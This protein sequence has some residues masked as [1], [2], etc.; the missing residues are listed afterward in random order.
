MGV[1][2]YQ[3]GVVVSQVPVKTLLWCENSPFG[4][5]DELYQ[6]GSN[7]VVHYHST[8]YPYFNNALHQHTLIVCNPSVVISTVIT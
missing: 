6:S 4:P 2:W 3:C 5:M 1:S 7:C 8:S